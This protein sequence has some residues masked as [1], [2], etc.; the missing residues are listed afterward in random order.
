MA[1][2]PPILPVRADQAR[3]LA[4]DLLHDLPERW[5]HT[6]GVAARAS[7]LAVTVGV[8]D[9]ELLVAAAWLHDIGYARHLRDTG[10]HP[11]DGGRHLRRHGWP[12]R[13]A[14]LVAHHSGACYVAQARGLGDAMAAEFPREQSPL[15]D[16]LTY[17]DQTIGPHGRRMTVPD[18]IAD[19]LARHGA[20][21]PN[22]RAH[23]RRGPFLLEVAS[24]VEHRLAYGHHQA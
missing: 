3:D 8:D 9:P 4:A 1:G 20:D 11:L 17:A 18:R 13:L 24:R 15:A 19:M 7:E 10:F 12:P 5:T 6:A 22:A 23:H 21:S 16:A 14:A 2:A